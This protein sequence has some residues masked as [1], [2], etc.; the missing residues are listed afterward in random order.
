MFKKRGELFVV[1]APSGTG[2]TTLSTMLL[3]RFSELSYSV[4]YTTR[5]PRVGEKNGIHY[6]FVDMNTFEYMIGIGDFIEYAK[7]HDNMYGTS[8]KYIETELAQ[9]KTILLDIDPQGA[10]QLKKTVD[11]GVF[12]FILPPSLKTL[13]DRL[14]ARKDTQDTMELRLANAMTEIKTMPDYDYVIVNDNL[15]QA[16]QELTSIYTAERCRTNAILNFNDYL[17]KC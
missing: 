9:G 7:V 4:S 13:R 12:V 5:P 17:A 16:F 15:Q 10:M 8:K 2:K 6:H 14:I 11:Y 3:E 1:S